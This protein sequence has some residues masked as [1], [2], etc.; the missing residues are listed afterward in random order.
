[1]LFT[2]EAIEQLHDATR[3]EAWAAYDRLWQTENWEAIA[4][5]GRRDRFFLL[6]WLLGRVDANR[7]WIY[8]RCREVEAIPV[9]K[10]DLWAREHY[11]S[12]IITLAGAIQ[13]VLINPEITI[14]IFSHNRPT[15]KKFLGQIKYEFENNDRLRRAYPVI[16]WDN[17]SKDAPKWSVERGIVV[18]RNGNP[19]EA[20]IEAHG[21]VDGM[22]TGAHFQLL[23]YD[24]VVTEASVTTPEMMQKTTDA[25]ALSSNL[26][27]EG[28]REWYAGTRYHFNDTY[29]TILERGIVVERRYPATIDGTPLG[30]P[31]LLTPEGLADKRNKQGPY[32]F[33]CQMLLNPVSDEV[34]GFKREWLSFHSGADRGGMNVYILC[35]PASAKKKNS[36]YTVFWV[37]ALGPNRKYYVL[38]IIRDRLNLTERANKLFEL[39]RQWSPLAVGYEKYGKDSDIEHFQSRMEI[40]NYHFTIVALGGMMGKNDRIRRLVPIFQQHNLYLPKKLEKVDYEGKEHD[41]VDIFVEQEYMGFPVAVHDD[42]LDALSRILD[43]NMP[44]VWPRSAAIIAPEK[45]KERYKQ[46]PRH[47]SSTWMSA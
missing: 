7:D 1:M 45:P 33:S 21:L 47:N 13:E 4:E 5:L 18:R 6:T 14:G 19:K 20:T 11:K 27:A 30:D 32:I 35:D 31:V 37:V 36:D 16:L 3:E 9:G 46:K 38:D 39:H 43:Y 24:D 8:A 17:P 34:Q 22:P 25:W 44:A 41:L 2:D 10:L 40:E 26:G 15:A 29:K 23:I 42:M 28:G 12:T